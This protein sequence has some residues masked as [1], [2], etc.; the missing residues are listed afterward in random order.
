MISHQQ[1]L[2]LLRLSQVLGVFLL[3]GIEPA[4]ADLSVTVEA[5]GIQRSQVQGVRTMDFDATRY[6]PGRY[7][8]LESDIGIYTGSGSGFAIIAPTGQNA[9]YGGASQTGAAGPNQTQYAAIGAQSGQTIME[10]KLASVANYFGMYWPAGDLRNRLAFYLGNTLLAE[11]SVGDVIAFIDN[12]S[13]YF[14]NPNTGQNRSEPYAY[15]NFYGEAG[16]TFDRIIFSNTNTTTGFE[17]DNHSV[18][19]LSGNDRSGTPIDSVVTVPE[20]ASI[21]TVLLGIVAAAAHRAVRSRV[22]SR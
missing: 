14:G 6:T 4:S 22:P 11:Y 1:Q 20:P 21:L 3:W 17:T 2:R 8:R 12:D 10:L 9:A 19:L 5:P 13:A 18:A 16:T 15:L 7:T